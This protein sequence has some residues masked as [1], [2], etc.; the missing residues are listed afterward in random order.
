MYAKCKKHLT[1]KF[2]SIKMYVRSSFE[3]NDFFVHES[4]SSQLVSTGTE[5]QLNQCILLCDVAVASF[6]AV[7][8][9]SAVLFGVAG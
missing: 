2:A 3:F 4:H 5:I 9:Y 8:F 7:S 6:V 1:L